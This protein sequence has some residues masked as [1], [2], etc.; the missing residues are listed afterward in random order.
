MPHTKTVLITGANKGIGYETARQLGAQGFTV[1]LGA[2]DE[3][4]GK[5]AAARLTEE[6]LKAC[7]LILDVTNQATIDAAAQ[8][9]AEEF[10]SLDVLINNA[11]AAFEGGVS[12]SQLELSDLKKTFETNFFGL[13]AVTKALLPLL[14][15]APAGRVVNVSSGLG[16]LSLMSDLSAEFANANILA[17]PSSKTAVNSLT[18]MFAKEFRHSPLKFNAADPGY[19]STDLTGN[20]GYRKAS[21]AAQ[22]IV[23]LATLPE[24]GP[25]GG[26]FNENGPVPW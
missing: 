25:T 22:V 6:G 10:G 24:E 4:R 21:Q 15:K 26:F 13:F 3:E 12:P 1:L 9:I 20:R 16:S 11:G 19:T 8:V 23:H 2:R 17:Y 14:I 5:E 7:P 18:L